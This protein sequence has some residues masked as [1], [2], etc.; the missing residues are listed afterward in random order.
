ML[1][2]NSILEFS[3]ARQKHAE[4]GYRIILQTFDTLT[5]LPAPGSKH[6]AL[7]L[8]SAELKSQKVLTNQAYRGK[9]FQNALRILQRISLHV[10]MR[11][12]S[13]EVMQGYNVGWDLEPETTTLNTANSV[14]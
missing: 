10:I 13:Q 4:L 14:R 1:L 3:S 6:S 9:I 2:S 7:I 5:R 8:I 12:E 11:S